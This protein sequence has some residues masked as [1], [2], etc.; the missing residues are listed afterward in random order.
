MHRDL[1]L[2]N[3]LV[4]RGG[5][6]KIIDYGLAKMLNAG[7]VSKTF[8]GTPEYLA[9]EMVLHQGHDYS[10]DWWALGILIYEM[11]IGVT[12]FYNRE[13]KLLLLK[14]R[15]SRVVFPDKRKYKID[16]S[17]EFVDLVLKL[18]NKDKDQRLGSAGDVQEVLAHPFFAKLNID[19]MMEY[20]MEP[21][22]RL[23]LELGSEN[24]DGSGDAAH[25][26]YFNS[27]SA[28]EDLAETVLPAARLEKLGKNAK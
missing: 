1:K 10:V 12:P 26:K 27:K 4:D 5:Y 6:L 13:R 23:D 20:R 17:D 24:P 3:V 28:P 21:P 25:H 2:E 9:P 14:I 22:L 15:Q 16:Y 7:Q 11:L 8:C 18:L 19:E